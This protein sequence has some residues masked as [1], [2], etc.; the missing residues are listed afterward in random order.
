MLRAWEHFLS[1]SGTLDFFSE[2]TM[3]YIYNIPTNVA[4]RRW[5][6]AI[7]GALHIDLKFLVLFKEIGGM[8]NFECWDPLIFHIMIDSSF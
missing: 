5:W 7:Y 4:L 8:M 6:R 2:Y 1:K 3:Y